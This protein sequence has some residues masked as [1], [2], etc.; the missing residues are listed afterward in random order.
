MRIFYFFVLLF[1]AWNSGFANELKLTTNPDAVCNNG[2]QATFTIKKA[3]SK[4][5]AIILPGGGVARNADEYK[6]RSEGMKSPELK[7]HYFGQAIEKDVEDKNYNM[8]FI[9]YCS[10]DLYQGNH[11]NIV[12]GKEIPFKGRVIVNDVLDQLNDQLK[13]AD[14]IIF[15]GYSAGAIGIGFHAERIG[16]YNNVRVLVDSF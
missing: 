8:V 3:K 14:E 1:F 9:P 6:S 2:E 16:Q 13:E 15:L 7:P 10:S 11:F 5:W 4:K 12:D